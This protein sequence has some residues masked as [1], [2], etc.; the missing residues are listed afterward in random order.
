M[1][2]PHHPRDFDVVEFHRN[3]V[4]ALNDVVETIGPPLPT[5]C[6]ATASFSRE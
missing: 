2:D 6:L 3:K 5:R 4:V 1:W